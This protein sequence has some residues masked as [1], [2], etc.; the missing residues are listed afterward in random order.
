MS[1]EIN[2]IPSTAQE[3]KKGE[4]LSI[5]WRI[6]EMLNKWEHFSTLKL[7]IY[8]YIIL[9]NNEYAVKQTLSY[10]CGKSIKLVVCLFLSR[11]LN[12]SFPMPT[13]STFNNLV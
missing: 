10:M 8:M 5:Y 4:I 1:E 6:K 12:V 13:I 3:G 7:V 2:E 11:T 9:I